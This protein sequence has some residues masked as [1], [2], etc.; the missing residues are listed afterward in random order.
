MKKHIKTY[1]FHK[2]KKGSIICVEDMKNHVVQVILSFHNAHV[3]GAKN[4]GYAVVSLDSHKQPTR[5]PKAI[6]K[7][8]KEQYRPVLTKLRKGVIE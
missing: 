4:V 3:I 7:R 2:S 8:F 1:G 6:A 5:T